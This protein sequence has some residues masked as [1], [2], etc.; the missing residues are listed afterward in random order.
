MQA[1]PSGTRVYRAQHPLTLAS[2]LGRAPQRQ[3]AEVW[4]PRVRGTAGH[5]TIEA[6]TK[7]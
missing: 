3:R 4:M 7:R 1:A 6:T 2:L 5:P